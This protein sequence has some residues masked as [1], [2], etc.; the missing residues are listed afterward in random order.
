M[1][2]AV[3]GSFDPI[4]KGHV[5]IIKRARTMYDEVYVVVLNN[6]A[7]E[8]MFSLEDRTRIVRDTLSDMD[9]VI[10][11]NYAGMVID[12]C[13]IHDIHVVVRGFRNSKDFEY[14]TLMSEWNREHG[15][16]ET[17]LLPQDNISYS[18][19]S[20]TVA[21]QNIGNTEVLS[22]YLLDKT[23]NTIKEIINNGK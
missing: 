16:I 8:Y 5:D 22:E 13:D 2:C 10:V 3:T 1:R 17:L 19:I 11:D 18:N 4:T 14:E 12:Y 23:I 21:R 9:R 6:E 7:K 15:S 20:S